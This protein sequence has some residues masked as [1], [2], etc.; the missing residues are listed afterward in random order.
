MRQVQ[1]AAL[2]ALSAAFGGLVLLWGDPWLPPWSA[3][4]KSELSPSVLAAVAG[5]V[6]FLAVVLVATSRRIRRRRQTL[7]PVEE[8]P[9]V[10]EEA[11]DVEEVTDVRVL[12][13]QIRA[14]EEALEQETALVREPVVAPEVLRDEA[15]AE[16]HRRIR[17]T[18]RGLAVRME[19]DPTAVQVLARV[20]AAVSRLMV[21]T[22]PFVRPTL[23]VAHQVAMLP[24]DSPAALGPV[25]EVA[26]EEAVPEVATREVPTPER[27]GPE[28]VYA[29][30]VLAPPLEQEVEEE[31]VLPIPARTPSTASPRGRRW[32]RRG[33]A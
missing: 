7:S 18:V 11:A 3:V 23:T 31:V 28:T 29:A 27:P 16:L 5:A 1:G 4:T 21:P 10:A 22:A 9:A 14:L 17:A 19:D 2:V 24:T 26:V 20:E 12:H 13:A 33:A 32:L 25:R 15:V 30:P 8:L 6:F